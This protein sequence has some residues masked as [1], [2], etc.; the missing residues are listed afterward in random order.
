MNRLAPLT[1]SIAPPCP[2][3]SGSKRLIAL[4]S[5]TPW[6]L[7]RVLHPQYEGVDLNQ[8]SDSRAPHNPMLTVFGYFM[9]ELA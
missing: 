5:V 4:Q 1:N 9:R 3:Q 2:A 7:G 6:M 8:R